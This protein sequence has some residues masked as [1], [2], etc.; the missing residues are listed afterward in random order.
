M[1]EKNKVMQ[2][3]SPKMTFPLI[4]CILVHKTKV[5][6]IQFNLQGHIFV[7][8]YVHFHTDIS[9]FFWEV[10]FNIHFES[11]FPTFRKISV[12]PEIQIFTHEDMKD[13]NSCK[14]FIPL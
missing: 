12:D 9:D 7:N 14:H 8:R 13:P 10:S 6:Q 3:K 1:N 2:K 5:V 4:F 11:S